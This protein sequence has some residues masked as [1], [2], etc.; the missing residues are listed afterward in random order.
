MPLSRCLCLLVTETYRTPSKSKPSDWS[1]RNPANKWNETWRGRFE[2]QPWCCPLPRLLPHQPCMQVTITNQSAKYT[3]NQKL[4]DTNTDANTNTDTN[5]AWSRT[6]YSNNTNYQKLPDLSLE[7]RSQVAIRK[8]EEISTRCVRPTLCTSSVTH[9]ITSCQVTNQK[10]ACLPDSNLNPSTNPRYVSSTVGNFRRRR[11]IA[12][13]W[14]FKWALQW[15]HQSQ[16]GVVL[17]FQIH[18]FSAVSAP[19]AVTPP[20]WA[21]TCKM[22]QL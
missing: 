2:F 11:D 9:H 21:P 7:L 12:K 16:L 8:G 5:T 19:G 14:F 1:C 13:Y 10:I 17:Q 4:C 22:D 20:S 15:L 3:N 18:I 6:L